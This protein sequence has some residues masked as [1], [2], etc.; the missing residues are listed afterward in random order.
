[1]PFHLTQTTIM[2]CP[3]NHHSHTNNS[4]QPPHSLNPS[5]TIQAATSHGFIQSHPIITAVQAQR[6]RP[7][8]SPPCPL[9]SNQSQASSPSRLQISAEPMHT[10]DGV[11]NPQQQPQHHSPHH[12]A[13]LGLESAAP[14]SS[15]TSPRRLDPCSPSPR[16]TSHRL[17]QL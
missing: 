13:Q 6:P 17:A 10:V 1:M 2:F 5:I 12:R 9:P 3:I 7:Q 15:G 11:L 14:T 8:T 4:P 16:R